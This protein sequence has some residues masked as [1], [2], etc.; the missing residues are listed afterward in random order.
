[1]GTHSRYNPST[2]ALTRKECILQQNGNNIAVT[3]ENRFQYVMMACQA[4]CL[5]GAEESIM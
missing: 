2:G 3:N 1:M 4:H 5:A